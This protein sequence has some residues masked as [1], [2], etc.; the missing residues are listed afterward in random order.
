MKDS[1]T[2]G[3]HHA[4][5]LRLVAAMFAAVGIVPG[6]PAVSFMSAAVRASVLRVLAPAESATRRL[7]WLQA[8]KLIVKLT[9]KRPAPKRGFSKG[10]GSGK[11]V[12]C[13]QLFDTRKHFAELSNT[14]RPKR[15]KGPGPRISGFDDGSWTPY[16]PENPSGK[17]PPDPAS[18]CR[19]LQ[20]L[21]RALEDIPAQA[22]RMARLQARRREAGEP[23]RKTEP[24][25]PGPPPGHR[26]SQTHEVDEILSDCDIFVLRA[27]MPPDKSA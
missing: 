15:A 14:R 12:P 17:T 9:A 23:P 20:A 11:A 7:I 5:L 1:A 3:Y 13:F 25:R 16:A 2:I 6:G 26:N 10:K 27:A 22:R 24:R 4:A 18:L 19:R 21:Q 8:R